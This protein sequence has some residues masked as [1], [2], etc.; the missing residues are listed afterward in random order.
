MQESESTRIIRKRRIKKLRKSITFGF[1]ILG[2]YGVF[3]AWASRN[4][5]FLYILSF[6]LISMFIY[7][8]KKQQNEK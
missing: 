2:I 5:I 3:I 6:F 7:R 8:A 1:L 4:N